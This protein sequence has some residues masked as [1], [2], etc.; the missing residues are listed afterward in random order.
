M[1]SSSLSYPRGRY[2]GMSSAHSDLD[3]FR[4]QFLGPLTFVPALASIFVLSFAFDGRRPETWAPIVALAA[5]TAL[6]RWAW[7]AGESLAALC[8]TGGLLLA[9]TCTAYVYPNT[10]VAA[11]FAPVAAIGTILLGPRLGLG[12]AAAGS[13]LILALR[14]FK[15]GIAD[16]VAYVGIFLLW[17]TAILC[18]LATYP[19]YTA[20]SWAW[21]S[22]LDG[23]RKTEEL[24]DSQGEL[25]R[26]SKSLQETCVRLEQ[27]SREIER[28][29]L[30]AEEAR[31]L[32]NEFAAAVSHE[33]RTPLNLVIG[34]SEMMAL[35]PDTSYDEPLPTAYRSDVEAIYRNACHISDL[36]DDVLDLSRIDAHRMAL[37]REPVSL[38]TVVD[39]AV[40]SV[41]GLFRDRKLDLLVQIPGDLPMVH[42]DPTRVR[43]ILINLLGN[44]ARCTE[45]G[46]VTVSASLRD[47][48]VVVTVADTGVGM[49]PDDIPRAFEPFRQVEDHGGPRAGHG[50][51]LAISKRFVEMH[52]GSMWAES[53]PGAGTT[54]HFT[55]PTCASVV[56]SDG[57]PSWERWMAARADT[58]DT[59]I[60]VLDEGG[61]AART[62]QRYLEGY[63]VV[64]AADLAEARRI[65]LSE[66]VRALVQTSADG[67]KPPDSH[68]ADLRGL[69]D[70]PAIFCPLQMS[71]S[72]A[73]ALGVAEYLT[74]PVSS[75]QVRAALR[76]LRRKVSSVLIVDDEPDVTR[77]L[78]RM[79]RS[80]RPSCEIREAQDGQ[81]AL[82]LLRERR[83]DVLLLDLMMPELDGYAVLDAM[84][85][86]R[87]LR[88]TSVIVITARGKEQD[89][90]AM[91]SISIQ[92]DGGFE[93]GQGMRCL[94]ASLDAL[95]AGAS[96]GSAP[97][98]PA[99]LLG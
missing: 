8:L 56:V 21:Y 40:A 4:S 20:L 13:L 90:M 60:L 10:P 9:L 66:P 79:I 87:S 24:R 47:H 7:R 37:H 22:Y 82:R 61:D 15:P 42:V 71:W 67:Q 25:G 26:L 32:K 23:L 3:E 19:V 33:L 18:W 98:Q 1:P 80:V 64:R 78:A 75:G 12:S 36:I 59:T 63:R 39:G 14:D 46:G 70:I 28:A 53:R 95:L 81:A 89:A 88:E 17:A 50:L 16:D 2:D 34:F 49:A 41:A 86:D 99:G 58:Q 31:R 84:R 91:T 77:L 62:M 29:R 94:K 48:E 85:G 55:L 44:A 68:L 76:R 83:P 73:R 74:K 57:T 5:V 27:L 30:A 45:R 43:Q 35:S 69:A 38:E 65:V 51:G 11:L 96:S 52:G 97:G 93:I 54:V 6:A 72:A 92:R